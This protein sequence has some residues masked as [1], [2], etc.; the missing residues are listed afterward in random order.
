MGELPQKVPCN[1]LLE[2][3]PGTQPIRILVGGAV[4]KSPA[5]LGHHLDTIARQVLPP[6]VQLIPAYM[7]D[8]EDAASTDLL[9]QFCKEKN[10]H[11]ADVRAQRPPDFREGGVT[12][13]WTSTAM[14]RVADLKNQLIKF[15]MEQK[16]DGL[17]LVDS[18]L[19]LHD[20]V[21]WSLWYSDAP[22]VC[23]VFWTKWQNR[24]DVPPMPQVW[25]RHPY[26][27]SGRGIGAEE[28]I[29]RLMRRERL[30]VWGQGA[31]TL[32]RT[33]CFK[34]GLSFDYLPDLPTEGMWVGED[35][36]LCTRAERLYLP[37][38]ADAWPDIFHAYHPTDLEP[39]ARWLTDGRNLDDASGPP[40]LG[41]LVNLTLEAL[42]PV[43]TQDGS[44]VH[45]PKQHTRGVLGRLPLAPDIEIEL[46][47]MKR[48]EQRIV[49]VKFPPW[50]EGPFR[51]GV[52]LI[53]ITLIDHKLVAEPVNT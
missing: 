36:H 34:K 1:V 52:R 19:F 47:E 17:W 23:G 2:N 14:R 45:V 3:L 5:I 31:C 6:N 42:E 26:E 28:F 29:R 50:A 11:Y 15:T 35:R 43:P 25:L 51:G 39:G 30:Q 41:E 48:G 9:S 8:N 53:Q 40:L 7:D 38:F 20:R 10:G 22:I 4:R 13:E 24:P 27:L 32:Y 33:E 49:S 21:F 37:M 12:H 46:L 16:A 18:D 44:M